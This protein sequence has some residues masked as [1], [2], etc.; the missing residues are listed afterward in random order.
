MTPARTTSIES[1]DDRPPDVTRKAT[2]RCPEC[3]HC[4]PPVGDWIC[5][6]VGDRE[7]R[8]CPE[9][10]TVIE[11]RPTFG[12]R[13]DGRGRPLASFNSAAHAALVRSI[14]AVRVGITAPARAVADAVER[15]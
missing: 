9:C 15:R 11:R 6:S 3:E 5:R 2:L 7:I 13:G 4:S 12:D 10:N 8:R 14:A 1:P